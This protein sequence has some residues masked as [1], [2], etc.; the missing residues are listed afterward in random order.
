MTFIGYLIHTGPIF[1]RDP[2]ACRNASRQNT[3]RYFVRYPGWVLVYSLIRESNSILLRGHREIPVLTATR[4]KID[5]LRKRIVVVKFDRYVNVD[6]FNAGRGMSQSQLQTGTPSADGVPIQYCGRC[7]VHVGRN[8]NP[9]SATPGSCASH[10]KQR[11]ILQANYTGNSQAVDLERT[12]AIMRPAGPA[13]QRGRMCYR[14]TTTLVASRPS[15]V[16]GLP[17]HVQ[18]TGGTEKDQV[19]TARCTGLR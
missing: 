12:T 4:I 6:G 13:M 19:D 10:R 15:M 16:H 17:A 9:I 3:A 8:S 1:H 7:A 11:S 18:G 2:N 5:V 14:V